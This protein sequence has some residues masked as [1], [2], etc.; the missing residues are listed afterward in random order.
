MYRI[1]LFA[2]LGNP[3]DVLFNKDFPS[4]RQ[5]TR[6]EWKGL[7]RS[8][9]ALT[10]AYTKDMATGARSASISPSFYYAP[11]RTTF[12]SEVHTTKDI[13]VEAIT[14]DP[15]IAGLQTIVSGQIRNQEPSVTTAVDYQHEMASVS[16]SAELGRADGSTIKASAVS[17][18][19]NLRVGASMEYF[20]S[21][22][23]QP[24]AFKET[25]ALVSHS[26]LDYEVTAGYRV[27]MRPRDDVK[28]EFSL[29]YFHRVRSDLWTGAQMVTDINKRDKGTLTFGLQ[30]HL[31]ED[32]VLKAKADTNGIVSASVLAA[33]WN[34]DTTMLFSSTFDTKDLSGK[35]GTKFGFAM[36][37]G[38][39]GIHAGHTHAAYILPAP[40]KM[41]VYAMP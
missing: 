15:G 20:A 39:E 2:T 27:D 37:F 36:T 28:S 30:Y 9:V 40:P 35:N 21:N 11:W 7:T 10:T 5:E 26:G 22:T 31:G 6:V 18:A 19:R 24:S 38:E 17:G 4:E 29:G 25:K 13:K 34:A 3:L 1:P 14:S 8:G 16:A 41:P 12:R 33:R 23:G 32:T